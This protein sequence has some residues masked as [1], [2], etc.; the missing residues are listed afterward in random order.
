M[1]QAHWDRLKLVK[2][3]QPNRKHLSFSHIALKLF[4]GFTLFNFHD[5]PG[6]LILSVLYVFVLVYSGYEVFAEKQF[7]KNDFLLEY[8]GNVFVCLFGMAF[9]FAV[10]LLNC[11]KYLQEE[12]FAMKPTSNKVHEVFYTHKATQH[13]DHVVL[14]DHMTN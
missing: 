6:I 5:R 4:T 12:P 10:N 7:E 11:L 2:S 13:L 8:R 9:V 1:E 3:G 14:W